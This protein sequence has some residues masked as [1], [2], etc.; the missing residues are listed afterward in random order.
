MAQGAPLTNAD[1]TALVSAKLGDGVILAKIS[2]SRCS[3]DTSTAGIIALKD[4]GVSDPVIAAMARC[5]SGAAPAADPND[6]AAKHSSGIY[7]FARDVSRK[8]VM[9]R[10]NRAAYQGT[11]TGG[12]FASAMTYGIKKAKVKAI[13]PGPKADVRTDDADATFYFYF[14]ADDGGLTYGMGTVVNPQQFALIK[15]E[16]KDKDRET[17]IGTAG[18]FGSSSGTDQKAAIDFKATQIADG[19]YN[20]VPAKPL[21]PGEYCFVASLGAGA[22][23]ALEIFDFG[24][25]GEK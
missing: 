14:N 17:V 16:A 13:I 11:H 6:P 18:A 1:V 21:K 19:V 8:Q 7:I 10:L 20:I 12:V 22:A 3:F 4:A 9:T 15:L 23:G 25:D 2:A 24:V 5:N